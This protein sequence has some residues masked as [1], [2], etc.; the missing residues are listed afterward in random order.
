MEIL[1]TA[2]LHYQEDNKGDVAHFIKEINSTNA[3]V[4]IIA[5][6][7][8]G[9]V[10][11]STECLQQFR[12]FPKGKYLVAGNHDLWTEDGDSF[13][14][15]S[16]TFPKL[17]AQCG[18]HSLDKEPAI[19]GNVGLVGTVGWYDYSLREESLK[20]PMQYYKDKVI[21]GIVT[22][23]DKYFIHWEFTDSEF[24]DYTLRGLKQHIE[25]IY[26]Q[27]DTIV[28]ALHH[29]PFAELLPD[30]ERETSAFL[31]A[32]AGS[33]KFGEL[34]LQYE[35]VQYVY[36]GHTHRPKSVEKAHLQAINIGSRRSKRRFEI[37]NL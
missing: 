7:V 2:D 17:A 27:V 12:D 11:L 32:F 19:L 3:E 6:D 36:C 18:F 34:L 33:K 14:I 10:E 1:L 9:G 8:S 16:S 4:L 25:T 35:K 28:C 20:V 24:V 21:P 5:G 30:V 23:T 31:N 13:E 15:Y 22:W 26:T 29:L 37:L